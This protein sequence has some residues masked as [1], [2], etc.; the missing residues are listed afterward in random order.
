MQFELPAI[1]T[2]CGL[3]VR[4]GVV[5]ADQGTIH[6]HGQTT[7]CQEC[8]GRA[9]VPDG[10]HTIVGDV[11]R[12]SSDYEMSREDVIRALDAAVEYLNAAGQPDVAAFQQAIE[13]K[14]PVVGAF[15]KRVLSDLPS[16]LATAGVVLGL[17]TA[18]NVLIERL[19]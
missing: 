1:C 11:L 7:T 9:E 10:T 18:L 19:T 17:T 3:V 15:V 14:S 13:K 4:S 8:G 2:R 6:T 12:W 5:V 16:D